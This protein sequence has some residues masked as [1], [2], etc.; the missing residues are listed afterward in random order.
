MKGIF[1][2]L[3]ENKDGVL[4]GVSGLFARR[5]YNIDSLA[6]G[7]T[8]QHDV[9]SMTIVSTGDTRT[10]DQIEK[11]LN[12]QVDVIKVRRLEESRCISLE[13]MLIRVSYTPTNRGGLIEICNVMGS[14]DGGGVY[15]PGPF[16][17]D[18]GGPEDGNHRHDEGVNGGLSGGLRR[19][20]PENEASEN[21][22]GDQ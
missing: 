22:T 14:G 1:S 8:E 5:G 6:V 13:M 7:E 10:I 15:Q 2:V 17:R 21:K 12:K 4:S 19:E 16:L 20:R 3:V 11:Q 9:S 18:P